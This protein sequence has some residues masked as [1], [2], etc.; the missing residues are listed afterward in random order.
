[1]CSFTNISRTF[2]DRQ[3]LC[4]ELQLLC[5]VKILKTANRKQVTQHSSQESRR[6]GYLK[7]HRGRIKYTKKKVY[8]G[9]EGVGQNA[10]LIS[11]DLQ[12]FCVFLIPQWHLLKSCLRL[13]LRNKT[14][15]LFLI[16]VAQATHLRQQIPLFRSLLPYENLFA[17]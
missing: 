17:A 2:R 14:S 3:D 10:F 7:S 16:G 9:L 5:N 8:L 11:R 15:L 12:D 1:M 13:L 6:K 4:T